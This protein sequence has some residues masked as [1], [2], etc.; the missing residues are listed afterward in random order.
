M[1]ANKA[2]V[3]ISASV[4]P[5][6][7]KINVSGNVVYDLNDMAGDN[8]KW[9]SYAM[10]ADTTNE[11]LIVADIGYLPNT[12]VSG[13]TPTRT[14]A[15]DTVEFLIIKH[16]G[17]RSDGTTT[18]TDNLFLNFTHGTDADNA[19]GNLVLEPGDVWWGR[20]AGAVDT[21]DISVEAASNDIKVLVYAVLDDIG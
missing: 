9:I 1:A 14:H 10:D 3:S 4:L 18:S 16:S 11:A 20:F 21:A 5:D 15:D 19:V 13:A 6:D 8:S 17:F 2:A 12:S 7:M